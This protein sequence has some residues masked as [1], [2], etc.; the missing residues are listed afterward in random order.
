MEEPDF[1]GDTRV[2]FG[3]HSPSSGLCFLK[4]HPW[5]IQTPSK[6]LKRLIVSS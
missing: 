2:G 4:P 3:L 6:T 5:R 1:S